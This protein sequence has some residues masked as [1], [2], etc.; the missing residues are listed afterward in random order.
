VNAPIDLHPAAERLAR[1][2]AALP[3]DTLDRPTPCAAYTVAALLD[4]VAQGLVAFHHAA[5]KDP[6]PG[7]PSGN[8]DHLVADWRTRIP[9]DART[10]ADAWDDPAAWTGR[11]AAGDV[12]LPG[13]VA[14]VVA[15]DEL[16]IHGWDLARATDQPADYDGPG[17]DAVLALVTEFR[18]RGIERLFGSEVPV[19][20]GAPLFDRIL[21]L[22]GRNPGW[23][24]PPATP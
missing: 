19:P 7:G 22:T 10:L 2:V 8:A 9:H 3:D 14:G 24:P 5:L 21:G 16:V 1:L 11:T 17:L 20:D 18:A 12:E 6:L 13:D 15:L 4:H 23:E